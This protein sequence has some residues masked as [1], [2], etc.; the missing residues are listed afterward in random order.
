MMMNDTIL[1]KY[2]LQEASEAEVE[3]VERW[4]S[5]HSENELRY[6][7]LKH[8][9]DAGAGIAGKSRFNEDEAWNHF[10][11]KRERPSVTRPARVI[12]FYGL[13]MAA[14]CFLAV[15]FLFA[16]YYVLAPAGS[17]LIS[18]TYKTA[19]Q[20]RGEV[21]SDGSVITMNKHTRLVFSSRLFRKERIV[22]MNEGEAFFEVKPDKDKPFIVHSG[23]VTITVVGTS[24]H[25]KKKAGQTEVIVE[26]GLVKV[27]VPDREAAL[28]PHEKVLVDVA[29]GQFK[30]EKVTDRLHNYYLTDRLEM[31]HTPL[32]RVAEVLEEAY[33]VEIRIIGDE[34]R[35]LRLTATFKMGPLDDILEVIGETFGI[36]V[37][38]EGNRI[39]IK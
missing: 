32:W 39:R 28:K 29:A 13:R 6:R 26:S 12:R 36:S 16:A 21:L 38:R 35:N 7:R 24:F 33:H 14:A 1:T 8:L 25:V 17:P 15:S 34:T 11:Q 23:E 37:S 30:E 10:L 18:S 31:E 20:V 2:L 3:T 4:I 5:A 9:W 27:K 19:S 22:E